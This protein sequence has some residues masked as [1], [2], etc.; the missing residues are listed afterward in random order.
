M[1]GALTLCSER[2]QKWDILKFIMIFLVVLGHAADYYTPVNE[3]MRALF[4]VI[5]AV[6]MPVFI[7][8]SGLFSKRTVNEKRTNKLFGYIVLYLALKFLPFIYRFSESD[9]PGISIFKEGSAPWFMLALFAFN[10]ITMFLKDR[11]PKFVLIFSIFLACFAGYDMN[12]GDFLALSRIIVFYPFFYLGYIT[13]REKLEKLCEN[14]KIKIAS[15]VVIAVFI[16]VVFIFTDKL[17]WLRALLT[18]RSSFAVF[19]G[20]A[21]RFGGLIRLGYY[22]VVSLLG[23]SVIALTP[24]KT[25]SG[26]MAKLGQ[27]TLSVYAFHFTLL[28]LFYDKFNCKELI[29][30]ALG[31]GGDWLIIPVSIIITLL[32]SA[33][34]FDK[35]LAF[36]MNASAPATKRSDN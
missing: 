31:R 23:F 5:Y 22:A 18:G 20:N 11:S 35:F 9:F 4:L 17:Y 26:I 25:H 12:I 24:S 28:Y 19:S 14:K 6:H 21:G 30:Q 32:L 34:I 29:G 1:K 10:L 7:F 8:V 2:T 36:I 16:A 33:S 27:R 3:K 13:E 15:A